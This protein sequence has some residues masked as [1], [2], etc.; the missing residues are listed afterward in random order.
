MRRPGRWLC[1]GSLLFAMHGNASDS[2]LS[3]VMEMADAPGRIDQQKLDESVLWALKELHVEGQAL[4]VIAVFHI[5]SSGAERLG[6]VNT[7]LWLNRGDSK[8]Y[9]LWIVGEPSNRIYSQMAVIVLERYFALDLSLARRAQAIRAVCLR[10]DSTV[11]AKSLT[12]PE[13]RGAN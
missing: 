7:S 12:P 6:I 1:I 9:E 10:L 11:S 5:S 4:P 8:R 13:I 3:L 2:R